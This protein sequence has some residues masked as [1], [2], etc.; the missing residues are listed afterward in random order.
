MRPSERTDGDDAQ[1]AWGNRVG[2]IHY[3][4]KLEDDG[5]TLIKSDDDAKLITRARRL[6]RD[7]HSVRQIAIK[8]AADGYTTRR[9]N[10]MSKSTVHNLLRRRKP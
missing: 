1:K 3:G 7:G 5:Q 4:K 2:A 8:L 6:Q 10:L 9:G